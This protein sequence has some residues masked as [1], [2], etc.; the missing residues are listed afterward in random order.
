[1]PGGGRMPTRES[2]DRMRIAAREISF[3]DLIEHTNNFGHVTWLGQPIWQNVLDL[4][5]IQEAIHEIRPALLIETGTHRGGSAYFYATLFDLLG[6]GR[7]VTVDVNPLGQPPHP[8][9]TYLTG[10]S[11]APE[12][13][14]QIRQ[15]VADAG[16][17]VMVILDSDHSESHVFAEM[18]LYGPLVTPGSLMLVQD[19]VIDLLPSMIGAR[20]GPLPAIRRFV[21]E[22]PEFRPDMQRNQKF[23]ISHHPNGWLRKVSA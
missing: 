4:W 22:H 12:I 10:S 23:P 6:Q 7:V 2:I 13:F 5:V 20:P 18:E 21:S 9:V 16:A 11:V 14:E 1:M 3:E 17:P 19:G 8:R 15:A